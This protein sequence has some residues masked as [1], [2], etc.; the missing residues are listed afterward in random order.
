MTPSSPA[1]IEKQSRRDAELRRNRGGQRTDHQNPVHGAGTRKYEMVQ[2]MSVKSAM[3][4]A[5]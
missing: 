3:D 1:S 2:N 4:Q 5:L